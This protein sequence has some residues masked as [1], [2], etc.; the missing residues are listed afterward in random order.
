MTFS[1]LQELG[2]ACYQAQVG[3][4]LFDFEV[5]V[6]TWR[7]SRCLVDFDAE[8]IGFLLYFPLNNLHPLS[9]KVQSQAKLPEQDTREMLQ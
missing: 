3:H 2:T 7:K 1:S 9:N 8:F 5:I 4:P 6:K